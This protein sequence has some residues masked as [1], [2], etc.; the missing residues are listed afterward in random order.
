MSVRRALLALALLVA[1]YAAP[2]APPD[3]PLQLPQPVSPLYLPVVDGPGA[4]AQCWALDTWAGSVEAQIASLPEGGCGHVW[5]TPRPL[6]EGFWPACRSVAECEGLDIERIAR[7]RPGATVLLLNEPNNP[8][9]Q[10][11]GWPVDP[12]TAAIRL[13]VL[14][15]ELRGAGLRAACCGLY[16]DRSDALGAATWWKAYAAAGGLSDVRHYHIFGLTAQ[17]AAAAKGL[18]EKAM[19]GPWIVS[20]AGFCRRVAD[21][22]QRIDSPHYIAVFT[23]ASAGCRE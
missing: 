17:D 13:A 19:P 16:V 8:D 10:G 5:W 23:L 3:S 15:G 20:E 4:T 12:R 14:V 1:G 18:A 6:P 9:V 2:P 22:V 7:E 11:G 21:Y